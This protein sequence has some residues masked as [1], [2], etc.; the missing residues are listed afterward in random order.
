MN[1]DIKE[2]WKCS[3]FLLCFASGKLYLI[4]I[5]SS[6]EKKTPKTF[7][8]CIFISKQKFHPFM[9]WLRNTYL[10][11]LYSYWH[12]YILV[13]LHRVLLSGIDIKAAFTLFRPSARPPPSNTEHNCLI[14]FY[15][16]YFLLKRNF[17]AELIP[18]DWA[19]RVHDFVLIRNFS[20]ILKQKAIFF[21]LELITTWPQNF[22]N[23]LFVTWSVIHRR[24]TDVFGR[25]GDE[26]VWIV[27]STEP[28]VTLCEC[29]ACI[30]G[31]SQWPVAGGM[32]E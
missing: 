7:L 13:F 4:S 12:K 5:D 1:T 27:D 10:Q 16:I 22:R 19:D 18:G 31:W 3:T 29:R 17:G 2:I 32:T 23:K 30:F 8:K 26:S 24:C 9:T 15:Y 21:E 6:E 28:L 14:Q 20:P 25:W 11:R